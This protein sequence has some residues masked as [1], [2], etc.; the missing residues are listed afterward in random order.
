MRLS[1]FPGR[2]HCLPQSSNKLLRRAERGFKQSHS[3]LCSDAD[4]Y[5]IGRR[6]VQEHV[7]IRDHDQH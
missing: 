4:N 7:H 6:G 3:G 1:S 2:I 5:S